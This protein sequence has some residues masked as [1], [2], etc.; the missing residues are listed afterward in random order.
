MICCPTC[1]RCE[2]DIRKI[3]VAVERK[4]KGL[5][6]PVRIAVMGCAVNGP[7]EARDADVGVAGG[8]GEGLLFRRGVIVGKVKEKGVVEAL[9]ALVR[10][11]VEEETP[12]ETRGW[13][14]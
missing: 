5:K 13:N 1:G 8:K 4:V 2:I 11:F 9:L 12:G 14:R 7:G 6:H 10:L 3:A